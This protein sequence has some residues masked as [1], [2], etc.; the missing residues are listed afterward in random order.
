MKLSTVNAGESDAKCC[1]DESPGRNADEIIA[2]NVMLM[3]YQVPTPK[4]RRQVSY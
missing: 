3:V 1:T 4:K 2:P